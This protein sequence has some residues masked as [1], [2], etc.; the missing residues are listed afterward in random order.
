MPYVK[1]GG[2]FRN[3]KSQSVKV[4]GQWRNVTKTSC[5]VNNVWR[6]ESNSRATTLTFFSP[7]INSIPSAKFNDLRFIADRDTFRVTTPVTPEQMAAIDFSLPIN[8]VKLM[9]SKFHIGT[10]EYYAAPDIQYN[11]SGWFRQWEIFVP[12]DGQMLRGPFVFSFSDYV[13]ATTININMV[14]F[15]WNIRSGVVGVDMQAQ[16]AISYDNLVRVLWSIEVGRCS[17]YTYRGSVADGS[18]ISD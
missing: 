4:N 3:V 8:Y 2:I 7:T 14:H 17:D 5:K 11:H 6:G 16:D 9:V 1:V 10:D 13:G 15:T 12:S 18:V